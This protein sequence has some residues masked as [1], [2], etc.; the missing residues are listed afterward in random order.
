VRAGVEPHMRPGDMERIRRPVDWFGLN[1]YS[2]V[3]VRADDHAMLRYDF[4]DKPAGTPL[5]PIGWPVDPAAFRQT[6]E[7]V[8]ARYGLPIYVLENGYGNHDSVDATGAVIDRD[9]IDFLRAYVSA[10]ND[11]ASGGVDVRGYF[12]WSLLDNFEWDSGYSVRFG[13][14]YVD[15]ASLQRTPKSSFGWYA[16]LIKAV[17]ER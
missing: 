7:T 16:G 13:L 9:R 17:G 8:H 3:Y 1:H 14:T 10:M 4:G 2:P 15:Y 12:V 5:T 11:A 6:L